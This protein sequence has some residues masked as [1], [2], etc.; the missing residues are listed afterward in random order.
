MKR[1]WLVTTRHVE[2]GEWEAFAREIDATKADAIQGVGS[3]TTFGGGSS[4][5][6]ATQDALARLLPPAGEEER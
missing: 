3:F 4:P 2:G 5:F 6:N 1:A